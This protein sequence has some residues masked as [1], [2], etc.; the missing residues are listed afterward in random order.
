MSAHSTINL[1]RGA[2]MEFALPRITI[3]SDEDLSRVLNVLL[4][5]R[6]RNVRVVPDHVKNDDDELVPF[7]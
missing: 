3:L 1:T 7:L 5:E 4:D 6:L 2:A